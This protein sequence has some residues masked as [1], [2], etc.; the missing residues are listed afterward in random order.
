M[1][2]LR[3]KFRIVYIF[4]Y[5]STS[6]LG[7]SNAWIPWTIDVWTLYKIITDFINTSLDT[8]HISLQNPSTNIIVSWDLVE[9]I[10]REKVGTSKLEKKLDTWIPFYI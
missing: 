3:L 9:Y 1:V 4:N 6:T 2:F 7:T 10:K 5:L 8:K